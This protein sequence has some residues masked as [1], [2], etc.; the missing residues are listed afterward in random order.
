MNKKKDEKVGIIGLGYVGLPLA[1]LCA[2]KGYQVSG[3]DLDRQKITSL[4]KGKSPLLDKFIEKR[5]AYLQE[6]SVSTDS[7]IIQDADILIIC[8]PTPVDK[9][10]YPDLKPVKGAV[11]SAIKHHKPGRLVIVESTINPGVCEEV[12][13]PMFSQ[14][15]LKEGKDYYLA[16]CPE[17]IDPGNKSYDVGNISRVI[18]SMSKKGVQRS[19]NFYESII[20]GEIKAMKFI[21]EAEAVKVV[22]NS[23]RDINIA[24]VNELAQSF[25]QMKIDV[26]DVIDGAATKPFAFMAHYPS[27]GVGGHCIPVDPY[28]LIE[29]AKRK[30][31]SHKFLKAAR[32]INNYMPLY[33]VKLLQDLLNEAEMP[34]KN[35]RVGI[36]GLSYKANIDDL[37]ESPV[38]KILEELEKK[39]AKPIKYDP[40]I[41]QDSDVNSVE[42]LLDQSQALMLI[43]NHQ[44]FQGVEDKLADKSV[45]AV[46]DGMNS[47]D[48]EKI[49]KNGVLYHG[50]G[51][52]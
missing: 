32:D 34:L 40:Y 37:R 20:D 7:E 31:F 11:K 15:G 16:H 44:E 50:I 48:G 10:Y 13:E 12:I 30:G 33:T 17:R 42:E 26:K 51:R 36:M 22:E 39:G 25:D 2:E 47:L 5:S 27:R 43:T 41:P 14:A 35:T 21:R 23:F 6:L 28:Y 1:V 49:K 4:Q 38:F 52:G 19:K 8:V 9:Y 24:F 46:V 18:G 3:C 45:K 29:Q